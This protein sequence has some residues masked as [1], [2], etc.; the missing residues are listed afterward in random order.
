MQSVKRDVGLVRRGIALTD[1]FASLQ[2]DPMGLNLREVG[3][4]R[5]VDRAVVGNKIDAAGGG[6][7]AANRNVALRRLD[8][9]RL[10]RAR[11]EAA[12]LP[13]SSTSMVTGVPP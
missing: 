3:R 13:A 1:G 5:V 9:D 4:Y 7:N 6:E 8:I 2:L 11:R 12:P 10:L